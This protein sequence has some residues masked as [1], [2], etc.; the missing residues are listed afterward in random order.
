[1]AVSCLKDMV[2]P[3]KRSGRD[4]MTLEEWTDV[5]KMVQKLKVC[6]V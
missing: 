2:V 6:Y 5:S 4:S 3:A 1:M